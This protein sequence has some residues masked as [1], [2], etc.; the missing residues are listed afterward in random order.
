MIEP[1]LR[2]AFRF[3]RVLNR[4]VP[5]LGISLL[6]HLLLL[7]AILLAGVSSF[8]ERPAKQSAPVIRAHAVD[9]KV[10]RAQ[11]ER[12][13][14]KKE[15]AERKKREKREAL[16]HKKEQ[17]KARKL[18]QR[19]AK[20]QAKKEEK[21]RKAAEQ[22]SRDKQKSLKQKKEREKAKQREEKRKAEKRRAEKRA[23]EKRRSENERIR[24][25]KR[26]Q[27]QLLLEAEMELEQQI[28]SR[29]Q[30]GRAESMELSQ[31]R[32]T[33]RQQI[34]RVWRKPKGTPTGRSCKVMVDLLPDGGVGRVTIV[35]SSG[36]Q[37]FDLS[38]ERAV[39]E[40]APFPLPNSVELRSQV[41]ELEMTFVHQE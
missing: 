22:K 12:K 5:P 4:R 19:R 26:L 24:Q 15:Q 17:E 25:Q 41:R 13:Q 1:Y 27:Q 38:V 33:I 6:L 18:K 21:K 28:L 8:Q 16:K 39:H 30:Q 3:W 36:S 40:A 9:G 7:F 23:A 35:S 34:E 11:E 2:R 10:L 37:P 32:M 31:I 29:E 14:R 20:E